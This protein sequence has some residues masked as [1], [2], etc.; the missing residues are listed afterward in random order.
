[1]S[2][3]IQIDDAVFI[4]NEQVKTTSLKVAEIFDKRHDH[5]IRKI[6]SLECSPEFTSTHFWGHVQT[7]EIGNGAT[8]ESKYYEMT[9]DGFIFL[10]MG[11]T[12]AAA[13]RIKEAY[14][15]TF[16]QMAAML[17]NAQGDH[18][19]IHVGA[20]V[21]LKA[22]GPIYTLSKIHYDTNGLMQD[23]EVIWHDRAKLCREVIPVACLSL[24]TKNLTQNKTLSDFWQSVQHYGI[25][26][27]NHSR[28]EQIL[29]LNITQVY[30]SIEGLPPKAQL[31]AI[32]M[33]S[34]SPY[35]LYMQHNH[36]IN[37]SMTD[38]TVRCWLFKMIHTPL[39]S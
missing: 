35:P 15:N 1:M 5:V 21:Q 4:Q 27:L 17:Y 33:Q 26:R 24:D 14:I 18:S 7:V 19:H 10:V 39:I 11:F 22:G 36:A 37:S 9:K 25:E 28:S 23:A 20:T 12:G 38:K 34:R 30:Q 31:S 3:L 13:A 29:A 8:R 6:E 16:N 32:L 2:T